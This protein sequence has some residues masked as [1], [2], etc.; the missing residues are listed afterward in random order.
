MFLKCLS[1]INSRHKKMSAVFELVEQFSY[2]FTERSISHFQ[3]K[4]YYNIK[5]ITNLGPSSVCLKCSEKMFEKMF[6]KFNSRCITIYRGLCQMSHCHYIQTKSCNLDVHYIIVHCLICFLNLT[7]QKCKK[8]NRECSL[9]TFVNRL[10][11]VFSVTV[12]WS[13]Q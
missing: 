3:I 13:Y 10:E 1:C 12:M 2:Y 8:E 5:P 4:C 7:H 11:T 9:R 6:E